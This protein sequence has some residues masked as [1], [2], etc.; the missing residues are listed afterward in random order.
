M[1]EGKSWNYEMNKQQYFNKV[2]KIV[3][4]N[5][6]EVDIVCFGCKNSQQFLS[7]FFV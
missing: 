2:N 6:G 3:I 7:F 5:Q 4:T 1:T